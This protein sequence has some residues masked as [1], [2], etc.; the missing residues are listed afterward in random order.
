M[1]RRLFFGVV[2]LTAFLFGC[3]ARSLPVQT[4]Q[5][6]SSSDMPMHSYAGPEGIFLISLPA[7]WTAFTPQTHEAV[8]ISLVGDTLEYGTNNHTL[9]TVEVARAQNATLQP[10]ETWLQFYIRTAVS[11]RNFKWEK[12]TEGDNSY[13]QIAFTEPA[14]G[15]M[16]Y[17]YLLATHD[18]ILS[19]GFPQKSGLAEEILGSVQ[20]LR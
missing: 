13:D 20:V 18:G 16:Q 5:A 11:P 1:K 17:H 19:F 12:V 9:M 10:D 8:P 3:D 7:N 6:S 4:D 2:V 14:D 15:L